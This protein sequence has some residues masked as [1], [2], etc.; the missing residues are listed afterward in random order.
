MQH[1]QPPKAEQCFH[2]A[3]KVYLNIYQRPT[4]KRNPMLRQ[5]SARPLH[6]QRTETTDASTPL[7]TP[8]HHRAEYSKP[9][10]RDAQK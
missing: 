5:D 10:R 3:C 9:A 2:S 1:R 6:R 8:N 7:K 4:V